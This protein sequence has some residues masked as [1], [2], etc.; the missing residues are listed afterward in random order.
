MAAHGGEYQ[1]FTDAYFWDNAADLHNRNVVQ[2]MVKEGDTN[3]T[4]HTPEGLPS[5]A[6]YCTLRL[7]GRLLAVLRPHCRSRRRVLAV[8]A[9]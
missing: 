1:K 6:K 4:A 9:S 8:P 2:T 5:V 7:P 3:F